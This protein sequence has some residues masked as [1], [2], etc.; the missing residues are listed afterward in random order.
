M[1]ASVLG[2]GAPP[3]QMGGSN[4]SLLRNFTLTHGPPVQDK[5]LQ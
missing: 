5:D 3:Y 4:G 1:V 2:E